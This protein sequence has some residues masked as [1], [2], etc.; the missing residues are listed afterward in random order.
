MRA[1]FYAMVL[2]LVFLS[3]CFGSRDVL[4]RDSD[5]GVISAPESGVD[6]SAK[7]HWESTGGSVAHFDARITATGGSRLVPPPPFVCGNYITESGELCDGDDLRGATCGNLIP[8][9]IG[10]LRCTSDC[11]NYDTSL[12]YEVIDGFN[13]CGNNIKEE[14][15][16]CD[17][18]DLAGETC[19][20]L[21]ESLDIRYIGTLGCLRNCSN[22]DTRSCYEDI[23]DGGVD[24]EIR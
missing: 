4:D 1:F 6:A 10:M 3:G 15:E 24:D 7:W 23:D 19:E 17:G 18:N 20:S 13:V 14:G 11:Q 21:S 5:G 22:Y 2:F 8:G 9:F 16:T 12:C